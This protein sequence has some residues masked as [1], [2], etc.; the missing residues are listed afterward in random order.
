[1]NEQK[2]RRSHGIVMQ[3]HAAET[4]LN[5]QLQ[6]EQARLTELS[7]RLDTLQRELETQMATDKPPSGK[8][9]N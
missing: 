5:A 3:E 9:P 2:C 8:R 7:D 4:Q 1:M 6:P